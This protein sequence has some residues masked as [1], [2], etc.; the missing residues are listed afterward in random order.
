MR[1]ATTRSK[2]RMNTK[3]CP[4]CGSTA[5]I[6]SGKACGQCG[7]DLPLAEASDSKA[8]LCAVA[9]GSAPYRLTIVIEYPNEQAAPRIGRQSCLGGEIVAL[10]F[11]D[12]LK[13]NEKFRDVLEQLQHYTSCTEKQFDLIED[14]LSEPNAKGEPRP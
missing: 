9:T 6:D 3:P 4:T 1:S 5:T 13:E 7:C 11:S 8:G 10:Q 2:N 14:A 12:A